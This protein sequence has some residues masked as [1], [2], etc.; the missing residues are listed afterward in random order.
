MTSIGTW[1]NNASKLISM[2]KISLVQYHMPP[3]KQVNKDFLRQVF[4]DEKKLMKKN[5]V[6]YIH[7][8]AYDELSVKR[9][10]DDLKN[11]KQFNIYFQDE[12]PNGRYPAREYFFNILNT[13]YP[14]YMK[15]I[16]DHANKERFTA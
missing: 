2:T 1:T 14:D 7:V 11:D 9:L 6:N 3:I 15:Q 16:M 4:T 8:P 5:A 13:V 10:W 12:Y